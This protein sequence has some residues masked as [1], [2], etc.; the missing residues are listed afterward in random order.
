[1]GLKNPWKNKSSRV[2]VQTAAKPSLPNPRQ[3]GYLPAEAPL[4]DALRHTVPL[5]DAALQKIV[6]LTVDFTVTCRTASAQALLDDFIS[7]VPIGASGVGLDT[8]VCRYLDSLLTYGSAV[9]EMVLDASRREFAGLYLPPLSNLEI[10][11]GATPMQAVIQVGH[12]N[13]AHLLQSPDLVFFTALNPAPGEVWGQPL[14]QGLPEI[15][16][17]LLQIDR[18]SVV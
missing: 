2:A 18:K 13:E 8:F 12:G 16:R 10:H 6:R 9:G 17:I 3:S 1:M 15:S 4:Y 14:L 7:R 11:E 5:I